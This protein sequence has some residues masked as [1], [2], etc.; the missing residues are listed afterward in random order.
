MKKLLTVL[1]LGFFACFSFNT[2]VFAKEELSL[3]E[4]KQEY[5][6][7]LLTEIKHAEGEELQDLVNFSKQYESL[8]SEEQYRLVEYFNDPSKMGDLVNALLE[9]VGNSDS[10][11]SISKASNSSSDIVIKDTFKE[12]DDV[13]KDMELISLYAAASEEYKI[14]DWTRD[15]EVFGVTVMR[16]SSTINY[17]RT[18]LGGV[19]TGISA[20]D[21]RM[22]RNFT[23]NSASYSG[24][25]HTPRTFPDSYAQSTSNVTLS[26]ISKYVPGGTYASG[27]CAVYVS[28]SGLISGFM[29][30]T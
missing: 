15:V 26:I 5:E 9:P 12:K 8:S 16:H 30:A 23:L 3:K 17:S 10:S 22:T 2:D 28:A 4:L 19:I 6:N 27:M 7:F 1:V 25:S 21:H 20:S 11:K 18:K 24:K 13:N 14:A 29:S